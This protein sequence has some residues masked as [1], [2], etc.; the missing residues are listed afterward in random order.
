MGNHLF[1]VLQ[2]DEGAYG[3]FLVASSETSDEV[4]RRSAFVCSGV[5][6]EVTIKEA[7]DSLPSV[8]GTIVLSAGTFFIDAQLTLNLDNITLKGK[9]MGATVL[10]RNASLIGTVLAMNFERHN[11]TL[12]DFT[13]D[14]NGTNATND[15]SNVAISCTDSSS[16]DIDYISLEIIDGV[17][18]HISIQACDDVNIRDCRFTGQI[19]P[20]PDNTSPMINITTAQRVIISNCHFGQS[21][22]SGIG[23]L[24]TGSDLV[25]DGCTFLN[26]HTA[27]GTTNA[28]GAI[29]IGDVGATRIS[30]SNCTFNFTVAEN[31]YAIESFGKQVTIS[32]C[33]ITNSPRHGIDIL[34]GSQEIAI[35][36]C[37]LLD[38]G[39]ETTNVYDDIKCKQNC[40][41]VIISNNVFT[42]DDGFAKHAIGVETGFTNLVISGNVFDDNHQTAVIEE[43]NLDNKTVIQGNQGYDN[44]LWAQPRRVTVIKKAD[45]T[46]TEDIILTDDAELTIPVKANK[47]YYVEC[48]FYFTSESE[49]D[50]KYK[51][52]TPATSTSRKNNSEWKSALV[53]SSTVNPETVGTVVLNNANEFMLSVQAYV[54]TT[55]AGSI[56]LMWAQSTTS[57]DP[58]TVKEGSMLTVIEEQQ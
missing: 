26:T 29:N 3:L 53:E 32:N 45:E 5:N 35:S 11:N 42:S 44:G 37:T 55:N 31:S 41:S 40:D 52:N 47:T 13:I 34:E 12:R 27:T 9:G 33:N 1:G 2:E 20:D 28:G 23:L 6:D 39:Q 7:F 49:P 58:T 25:I 18:R 19:D 30:I 48:M 38:C 17:K 16:S 51:I 22:G 14:D 24:D 15:P 43:A 10:K 54:R 4:K 8:G 57:T 21:Y 46:I 36:N 56:S 50:L